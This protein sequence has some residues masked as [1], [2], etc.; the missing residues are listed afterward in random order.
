MLEPLRKLKVR[1]TSSDLE[2]N[3]VT[4]KIPNLRGEP[5]LLGALYSKEADMLL[6]PSLWSPQTVDEN[7]LHINNEALE[8]TVITDE[9]YL[10]RMDEFGMSVE[11]TASFMT[12]R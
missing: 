9:G 3:F 6:T 11:L 10:D 1:K 5:V 2:K 4:E 7:K 12:G 8:T